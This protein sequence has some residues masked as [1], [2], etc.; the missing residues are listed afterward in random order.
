MSFVQGRHINQLSHGATIML[1]LLHHSGA[2]AI[3]AK[4]LKMDFK[5]SKS[6]DLK[7]L[8]TDAM[9]NPFQNFSLDLYRKIGTALSKDVMIMPIITISLTAYID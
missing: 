3:K 1:S 8:L 4:T 5:L 6:G 7:D 2:N 9:M